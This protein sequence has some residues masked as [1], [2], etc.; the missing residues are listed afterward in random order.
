MLNINSAVQISPLDS[1]NRAFL[2][3]RTA[4]SPDKYN[5]LQEGSVA[6]GCFHCSN[7]VRLDRSQVHADPLLAVEEVQ[8]VSLG[9]Q[10]WGR[11]RGRKYRRVSSR[12]RAA[13]VL[14]G[15]KTCG[16]DIQRVLDSGHSLIITSLR[17]CLCGC[18]PFIPSFL[19]PSFFHPRELRLSPRP[20]SFNMPL[21]MF[22]DLSLFSLCLMFFSIQ[23]VKAEELHVIKNQQPLSLQPGPGKLAPTFA[24]FFP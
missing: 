1:T 3:V 24:L 10:I 13:L 23:F 17:F 7:I 8:E 16:N 11:G 21:M 18:S 22:L 2:T 4:S 14:P 6:N 20:M 9:N 19:F 12:V 15:V 5:V